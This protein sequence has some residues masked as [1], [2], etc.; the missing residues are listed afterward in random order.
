MSPG[1]HTVEKVAQDL[2]GSRVVIGALQKAFAARETAT[3][4]QT[5]TLE[6]L[7]LPTAQDLQAL[8]R[9]VRSLSQRLEGIEDGVDRVEDAVG[10]PDPAVQLDDR[11]KRLE[12]QLDSLGQDLSA[13]RDSLGK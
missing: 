12:K 10:A 9:R 6:A 1:V 13:V 5:A 4:V 8:A 2:L 3:K 11:L 7:N